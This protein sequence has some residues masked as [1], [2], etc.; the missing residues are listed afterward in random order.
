[1]R[2]HGGVLK[3][4]S[5]TTLPFTLLLPARN[6]IKSVVPSFWLAFILSVNKARRSKVPIR[7]SSVSEVTNQV[8]AN[9]RSIPSPH[10]EGLLGPPSLL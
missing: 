2:V 1:M 3:L 7:G 6:E 4:S 5:G 9:K 10:A 8:L